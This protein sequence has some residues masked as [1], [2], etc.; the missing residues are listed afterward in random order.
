MPG[1]RGESSRVQPYGRRS[2]RSRSTQSRLPRIRP[3]ARP[4]RRRVSAT[5]LTPRENRGPDPGRLYDLSRLIIKSLLA[6]GAMT[7]PPPS[8]EESVQ[9]W[10]ARERVPGAS[11]TIA[12][13]GRET[14]SRGY[15]YRDKVGRLPATPRTIYGI[16]SATKSFTAL[17]ILRLEEEGRLSLQDPIAKHL[18]EF[19]TPDPRMARRI[20]VHHFLT[21]TSGL[22]PLPTIVYLTARSL[23][24]DPSYDPREDRRCGI[25]PDHGPI[26]TYEQLLE[27]LRTARYRLLGPP[28]RHFSYSNEAFGL[29]G[30]V[31]E[32]ASG[33]TYE[34]YLDE[35]ILRPLGMRSTTFDNGIMLRCP[36]V[37]TPYTLVSTRGRRRLVPSKLWGEA[38][39]LRA[40]GG[41][42]SNAQDLSRFV[43]LF[44]NAGKVNGERIV[45]AA[46]IRRMTTPYAEAFPGIH[47]GYGIVVQPDYH[48][49]MIA[50]HGGSSQGVSSLFVVAPRR[51]LGGAILANVQGVRPE[52]GLMPQINARMGLPLATPLESVPKTASM[53]SSLRD[54][55]GW[56]GSG[57]G[58]WLEVRARRGSLWLYDHGATVKPKGVELRAAGPDRF[59]LRSRGREE[60]VH[61]ERQHGQRVWAVFRYWRLIRRRGPRAFRHAR[62]LTTVW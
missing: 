31:I 58:V 23:A 55:Q 8:A 37:T 10:M 39:C 50:Y 16:A 24:E 59:V 43:Q 30:A 14:I 54:F 33:R 32:R 40:C 48:G 47:Y 36:D 22:P 21:H 53:E 20:T 1:V 5:R 12:E 9:R 3:P 44:L 4:R 46:T 56:Y 49:T 38:P 35:A 51:R 6:S 17:A 2:T 45:A 57:E 60:Q 27:Y 52:L 13:R 41:L 19:R 11:L 28:G 25:D 62:A 18:P 26:D 42:R 15:G 29:L 61:F 7:R 34:G